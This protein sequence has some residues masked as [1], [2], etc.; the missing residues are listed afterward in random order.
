MD[1][2][3]SLLL[4][5]FLPF[6]MESLIPLAAMALLLIGS[7]LTSA[8]EVAFFSLGP[9]DKESLRNEGT[10]PA[11]KVHTVL[12]SP[13]S[14]L[15]TLLI[16]NNLFNIGLVLCSGWA[17]ALWF[18]F[19]VTSP[20]VIILIQTVLITAI[21]L[22]F[23]E[24]LPKTYA[25]SHA[26]TYAKRIVGSIQIAM[27]I[28]RPMSRALTR[29]SRLFDV[30]RSK[31]LTVDQLEDALDLTHKHA[32]SEDQHKMLREIVRFGST[33][34]KEIMTPRRNMFAF[35]ENTPWSEI[36]ESLSEQ[37]YSRVPVYK[38]QLDQI[39]G[40]LHAK[41]LIG[42]LH[43]RNLEWTSLIRQPFFATEGMKLDDLLEEFRQRRIH[44]A[45]VVDEHG[46]VSGLATLEDVMEEIVGEI[47]DEFD[48]E[49]QLYSRL[50]DDTYVFEAQTSISDLCR[51]TNLPNEILD[52]YRGEAD[53][54]AGVLLEV[55]ERLPRRGETIET[56]GL[57]WTIESAD[58]RHI[59]RVKI[60]INRDQISSA[61]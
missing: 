51:I 26:M 30:N 31:A 6:Q 38:D 2:D 49:E 33:S 12:D 35:N 9:K 21:L 59:R 19:S 47:S 40:V 56:N 5:I 3:P 55:L 41:D 7:A 54:I 1:P 36:I 37:G 25:A 50:D 42:H 61:S 17:V 8:A 45:I 44:M 52:A 24:V 34:T 16:V 27:Q 46:G 53:T 18:D 60:H 28:T 58:D 29:T 23:G 10:L 57:H 48:V 4:S 32:T 39:S 13:E 22:I 20:W 15:A 11:Q 43:E 14:L